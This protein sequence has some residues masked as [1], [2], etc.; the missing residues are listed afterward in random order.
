[1]YHCFVV[2][3]R[4]INRVLTDGKENF[5]TQRYYKSE[6]KIPKEVTRFIYY[7]SLLN[8]KLILYS[9]IVRSLLLITL[10][11]RNIEEPKKIWIIKRV[12]ESKGKDNY[13]ETIFGLSWDYFFSVMKTDR[14]TFR[15]HDPLHPPMFIRLLHYIWELLEHQ[16]TLL[17]LFLTIHWIFYH[18][19]YV[20]SW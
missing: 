10:V 9:C 19:R 1:M 4:G 18:L 2:C 14:N 13:H 11:V 7:R 12:V 5:S 3:C 20:F 6:I 17:Y 16:V 15:R 8:V